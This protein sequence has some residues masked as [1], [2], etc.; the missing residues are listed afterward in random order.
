MTILSATN[1]PS[2]VNQATLA[3]STSS[4]DTSD[5]P[6]LPEPS[7]GLCGSSVESLAA[8]I[9]QADQQ[10][11]AQS[12]TLETTEDNAAL[13]DSNRQVAALRQKA[14]DDRDSALANGVGEAAAGALTM[15]SAFFSSPS[16]S[17]AGSSSG[18]SFNWNSALQG[19][20]K[21]AE[22]AADIVA[23]SK[24]GDAEQRDADAAQYSAASQA[25]VRA[26]EAARSDAQDADAS[27]QKVEQFLQQY[28][29]A[30]NASQLT[31]ASYR[32]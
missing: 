30:A 1:G 22:G 26:Y 3:G 23:A 20:S 11:R 25:D 4:V 18:Q 21:A 12:R 16:A 7:G 13:Q 31:A 24:K 17:T 5:A 14:D 2:A 29:Q 15:G 19:G 27:M 8:L 32:A 9:M 28:Q 10:D 6:L